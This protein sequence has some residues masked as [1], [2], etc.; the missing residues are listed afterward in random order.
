MCCGPAAAT[1]VT[2]LAN[3]GTV[4]EQDLRAAISEVESLDPGWNNPTNDTCD[5][6]GTN[7]DLLVETIEALGSTLSSD[8]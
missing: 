8:S 5:S 2:C 1:M 4:D 6:G 3:E 7:S